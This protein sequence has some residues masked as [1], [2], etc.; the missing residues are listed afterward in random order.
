[1]IKTNT[2]IIILGPTVVGKT[3][4]SILLAKAL[5]TEIISADSMQVY[6]YMDLGTAKPSPSELREA[7]HHLINILS[8]EETFS[9]G[10]F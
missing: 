2:V 1:M 6:R 10:L 3:A 5:N 9:A 4:F 8:P 7:P